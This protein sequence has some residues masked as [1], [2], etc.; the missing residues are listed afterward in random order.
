LSFGNF[1]SV[2]VAA[3]VVVGNCLNVENGRTDDDELEGDVVVVVS[4]AVVVVASWLVAGAGF[5]RR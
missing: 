5:I 4:D 1:L 2:V 3:V